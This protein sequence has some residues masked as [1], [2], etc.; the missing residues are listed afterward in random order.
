MGFI[1]VKVVLGKVGGKWKTPLRGV[2][3]SHK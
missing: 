2:E 3:T 1:Y